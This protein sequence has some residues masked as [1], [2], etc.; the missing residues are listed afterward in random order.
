MINKTLADIDYDALTTLFP[1]KLTGDNLAHFPTQTFQTTDLTATKNE[2]RSCKHAPY[3]HRVIEE[4]GRWPHVYT[5]EDDV[6]PRRDAR[7]SEVLYKVNME[8]SITP[9]SFDVGFGQAYPR[10]WHIAATS[11]GQ[12]TVFA[13]D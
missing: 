9:R 3:N 1:R 11:I 12:S 2:L 4:S 13:V 10:I 8:H 7:V 6:K 5:R